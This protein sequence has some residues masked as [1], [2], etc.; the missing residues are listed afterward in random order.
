MAAWFY[1]QFLASQHPMNSDLCLRQILL[2]HHSTEVKAK[3]C[4]GRE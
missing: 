1:A 4:N 2:W 3:R